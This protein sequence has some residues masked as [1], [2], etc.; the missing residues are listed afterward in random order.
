MRIRNPGLGGGGGRQPVN[1][2][3][4]SLFSVIGSRCIRTGVSSSTYKE[5]ESINQPL[6]SGHWPLLPYLSL[7]E[8]RRNGVKK[9]QPLCF[10]SWL[11]SWTLSRGGSLL[12]RVCLCTAWRERTGKETP[13]FWIRS[14]FFISNSELVSA[15]Y[16]SRSGPL[17]TCVYVFGTVPYLVNYNRSGLNN[18]CWQY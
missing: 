12:E 16:G 15:D 18:N 9:N 4:H 11:L 2:S 14:W 17:F 7:L 5:V 3:L 10:S 13:A 8:H 1:H 6:R